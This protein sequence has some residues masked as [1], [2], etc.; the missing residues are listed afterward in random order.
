MGWL[1]KLPIVSLGLAVAMLAAPFVLVGDHAADRREYAEAR[2]EAREYYARNPEL[3]IDAVGR[4]ILD[5]VWVEETREAVAAADA[6]N[7]EIRVELPARMLARAQAR[8]DD[9]LALAYAAR[10]RADPTWRHGVLDDQSPAESYLLHAF[11]HES[12]AA[13]VLCV[14]VLVFVGSPLER[15]WGSLLFGAFALGAIPLAAQ[16]HR[17]L[18]GVAGVPWSGSTGLMGAIVGAY[19]IRGLG[20]HFIIPGWV[21]LPAWVAAESFVVR[22]FWLDD[23]GAVPWATLCA[24]IAIGAGAAG[25]LRLLNVEH[26]LD[27][28]SQKR[29]GS[30]TNPVVARAARLRSDGDPYQA[31]DLIQAAWRETP[32]DED[33]AEAFFSIAVEVDQPEAA[34]QAVV[35]LLRSALRKGQIERALEYW[36]PLATRRCEV[37]LEPTATVRLGEALLDAGHPDEA[38]FSLQQAVDEGVSPAHAARIVGIARDLDPQLTRRAAA[39]ALADPDLDAKLR[40]QLAPLVETPAEAEP[41]VSI[42]RTV[43]SLQPAS[44]SQLDRRVAAEHHPVETT[45]FPLDADSDFSAELPPGATLA[46]DEDEASLAE[47]GL[48]ADAFSAESLTA[49]FEASLAADLAAPAGA[50][51]VLSHWND[52]G[53]LDVSALEA[54]AG[55]AAGS[56]PIE[57]IE[58]LGL[59]EADLES[60][61]GATDAGFGHPAD[62]DTDTDFTPMMDSTDEVTS[63]LDEGI[64]LDGG[65]G[66]AD[67]EVDTAIYGRANAGPTATPSSPTAP[68]ASSPAPAPGRSPLREIKV[69]DAMPLASDGETIEIDAAERG[70]SKLPLTRIQAVSMVAVE[71]LSTRPVLLVDVVLNWSAGREEAMK[72]IRFRSDRFDPMPFAPGAGSP[73]AA[74]TAWVTAIV[75]HSGASCLPGRD[76]LAGRFAR[77]ASLDD[78]ER[79][80]LMGRREGAD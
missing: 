15:S 68:V 52:H 14:L 58:E 25:G 41:E 39:I 43:V 18:D 26:R 31:F 49:E 48:D 74:M 54:G 79:E 47:Q 3:E 9:M 21:V 46:A 24:A 62:D 20:G 66:S 33:V 59:S 69:L 40:A 56:A 11:V 72:L 73:L 19:F 70:K 38:L 75:E 80:V 61:F 77:F 36:L 13:L 45:A 4:L 55:S 22:G 2:S 6:A 16:A 35:P 30:G 78:Y 63:P 50:E 8:L 67:D 64:D 51:D 53:A 60:G 12:T 42:E 10:M 32:K 65:G 17:L 57:S 37:R 28:Q 23:L 29:K 34:A 1:Q 27:A 76:I 71:G 44:R 5:P 7:G